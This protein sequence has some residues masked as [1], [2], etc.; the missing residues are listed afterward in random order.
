MFTTC[1]LILSATPALLTAELQKVW[2][3]SHGWINSTETN[4]PTSC[5]FWQHFSPFLGYLPESLGAVHSWVKGSVHLFSDVTVQQQII[6]ML[7]KNIVTPLQIHLQLCQFSLQQV[8]RHCTDYTQLC[9]TS[10]PDHAVCH[11]VWVSIT[12]PRINK[13]GRWVSPTFPL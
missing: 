2:E 12:A 13:P 4:W 7:L 9:T 11:E 10:Q 3:A 8:W 5:P 6:F 1:L